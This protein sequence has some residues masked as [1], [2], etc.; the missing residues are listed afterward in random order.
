MIVCHD[1]NPVLCKTNNSLVYLGAWGYAGLLYRYQSGFLP[2][3]ST[4]RQLIELY[5]E[6][7]LALDNGHL[8]SVIFCDVSKAFDRV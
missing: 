3:F 7:L 4:T 8:T 1:V 6:I 5:H 2:G